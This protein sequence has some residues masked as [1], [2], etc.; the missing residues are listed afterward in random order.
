[1]AY[2][3]KTTGE[4]ISNEEFNRKFGMPLPETKAQRLGRLAT[5]L[6]EQREKHLQPEKIAGVGRFAKEAITK[7]VPETVL[8]T[9]AKFLTS[10][11]EVP[12]TFIKGRATQREYKLPGIKPFKSYISEAETRAKEIVGGEKPLWTA[13]QPFVEVPLAGLETYML[14]KGFYKAGAKAWKSLTK[15]SL[16]SSL[17]LTKPALTKAGKIEAFKRAGKPGGPELKGLKRK[18]TIKPTA[19]NIEVAKS[20][21]DTISSRSNPVDNV[22]KINAKIEDIAVNEITPDLTKYKPKLNIN[23]LNKKLDAIEPSI[24]TKSEKGTQN[25]FNRIIGKMKELVSKSEDSLD[26]W[27]ARKEFDVLV[28]R[29]LGGKIM[30]PGKVNAAKEAIMKGRQTIN[31]HI[32]SRTPGAGPR[33]L[34]QMEQMNYMYEAAENISS[35]FYN[36]IGTTRWSRFWMMHPALKKSIQALLGLGALGYGAGYG[37]SRLLGG[38]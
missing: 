26:L 24:F 7:G 20:V 5:S 10:A 31:L 6:E 19:R 30:E 12:E 16:K 13:A 29:E 14:G 3:N 28:Q 17:E 9:P 36:M 35:N 25:V 2:R 33:F 27:N 38:E 34:K 11:A 18:I 4:I 1:M 23:V 21:Q 22:A 32:G 15:T 37:V 8:G